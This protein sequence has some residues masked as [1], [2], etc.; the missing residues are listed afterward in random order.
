MKLKFWIFD[1]WLPRLSFPASHARLRT[2]RRQVIQGIDLETRRQSPPEDAQNCGEN[3]ITLKV[4][5]STTESQKHVKVIFLVPMVSEFHLD[6]YRS[7]ERELKVVY[8]YNVT[9]T[10]MKM[11][12][13]FHCDLSNWCKVTKVTGLQS[14][15]ECVKTQR[16]NGIVTLSP[17]RALAYPREAPGPDPGW[18]PIRCIV[19]INQLNVHYY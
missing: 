2:P 18:N 14:T 3:N 4:S 9:F 10:V 15:Y 6:S 11:P 16:T 17:P 7:T 1:D 5:F 8:N 12:V 13:G 19:V